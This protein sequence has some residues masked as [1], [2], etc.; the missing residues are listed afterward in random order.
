MDKP[1]KYVVKHIL[2]VNHFRHMGGFLTPTND[3]HRNKNKEI[4][5]FEIQELKN[6]FL[7][8]FEQ[9]L[10]TMDM[11]VKINHDPYTSDIVYSIEFEFEIKFNKE[12]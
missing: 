3:A 12:D 1:K 8:C 7:V 6:K 10:G 5:D 4:H 11:P 2:D 9:I